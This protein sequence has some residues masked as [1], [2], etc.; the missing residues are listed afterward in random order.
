MGA[1]LLEVLMYMFEQ[2]DSLKLPILL[3]VEYLLRETKFDDFIFLLNKGL[4]LSLVHTFKYDD[5]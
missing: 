2:V 3:I 1:E 5:A 4:H